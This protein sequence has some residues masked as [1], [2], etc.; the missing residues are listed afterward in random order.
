MSK[1]DKVTPNPPITSKKTAA[2][3]PRR[4]VKERDRYSS[5]LPSEAACIRHLM[6]KLGTATPDYL[7]A[8]HIQH[9]TDDDGWI[10]EE[11]KPE[12][13]TLHAKVKEFQRIAATEGADKEG[14]FPP[15]PATFNHDEIHTHA[16]ESESIASITIPLDGLIRKSVGADDDAYGL[17]MSELL[18]RSIDAG[19]LLADAIEEQAALTSAEHAERFSD[20]TVGA[21]DAHPKFAAYSAVAGD[22]AITPSL[23]FLFPNHPNPK[24][25]Q[26]FITNN[27]AAILARALAYSK[28][29]GKDPVLCGTMH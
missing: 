22:H 18:R 27:R 5:R 9:E 6:Q 26:E 15:L 13:E 25:A 17:A 7:H 23:I 11:K 29:S 8:P 28:E 21:G 20:S 14:M 19:Y 24:E 12:A 16:E 10:E 3:T 4:R 2:T 1:I